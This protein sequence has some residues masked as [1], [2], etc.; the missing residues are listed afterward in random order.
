MSA[1]A[2]SP[3]RASRV[4]SVS[5]GAHALGRHGALALGRLIA[6]REIS[7]V[8]V[9]EDFLERHA[10]LNPKLNAIVALDVQGA[11]EAAR[12]SEA[13]ALRGERLGELDGIPVTV[14][15]NLFVA[16]MRATWGSRLYRTFEPPCD[17]IGIARLRAAGANVVAKTNTPEFALAAHTDNLVFGP[18]RNPWD[19]SLT[20]GGSSG[21][22]AAAL[23]AG[24]GPLA[25]GT[26]AGGSIR[27]PAAYTG[28]V[29]LRPS[30]GRIPRAFGFPALAHDFQV[31]APAARTVSDAYALFRAIAGPDAR[32]RASLVFRD[33]PLPASLDDEPAKRLRIRLLSLEDV[34]VDPEVSAS[35]RAAARVLADRGH[36]VEEG[37][38]PYSVAEVDRIWSVLSP[39]G[40]AR[41]A[42]GHGEWSTAANPASRAIV[43][44]GRTVDAIAYVE[45]LEATQALR[46]RLAAFFETTDILLSPASASLPWRLEQGYPERIAG[47]PAGPRAAAVFA[48]FVNVGGLTAVSVP[49]QPTPAGIPIGMQ[50]AAGFGADV[51]VLRLAREL[52]EAMPWAHRWPPDC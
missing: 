27:R 22:A 44:L 10:L 1:R 48:T 18:T 46:A 49:V 35:V 4:N 5:A 13:R 52:E 2:A 16:G 40:L 21:G 23:A 17:D 47:V 12:R 20:P 3:N 51:R 37:A 32:D 28:V 25:V 14:K 50:I 36:F 30:T 38:A 8:E 41:V 33:A 42:A 24:M 39:A 15:D 29:G 34:Q 26:D 9:L 45:A 11:T 43:E 6:R 19:P 7:P 31:V